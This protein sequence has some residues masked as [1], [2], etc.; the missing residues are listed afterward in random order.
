MAAALWGA[1]L[2]TDT[3]IFVLTLWKTATFLRR[4]G[5]I[6]TVEILLRDGTLYFL[7]IF[8]VNLMNT[9][10]YFLAQGDLKAVGASF[11]QILTSI[12]I[13]R[14]QLNLRKLKDSNGKVIVNSKSMLA[15]R[16]HY[17]PTLPSL[18]FTSVVAA[19][20]D[21]DSHGYTDDE[22]SFFT[23]GNLGGEIA[24]TFGSL[25]QTSRTTTSSSRTV[26]D[27]ESMELGTR[28]RL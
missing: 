24:G 12:M 25:D 13:S 3:C 14:L 19:S 7:T 20:D 26:V 1:P 21:S 6:T 15:N 23:V 22:K 10:I 27:V 9:L 4:H 8:G 2:V 16:P 17:Q 28:R 5:R 11:S 18:V